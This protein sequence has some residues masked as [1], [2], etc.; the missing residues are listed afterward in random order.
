MSDI[1]RERKRKE[2]EFFALRAMRLKKEKRETKKNRQ[3]SGGSRVVHLP[4]G[5][6]EKLGPFFRL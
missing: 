2:R 4:P 5:H 3:K 6:V 1:Y